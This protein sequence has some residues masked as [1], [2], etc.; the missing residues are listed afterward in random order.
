MLQE[1]VLKYEL[2]ISNLQKE[3]G[4][5]WTPNRPSLYHVHSSHPQSLELRNDLNLRQKLQI[6]Q[7]KERI[8]FLQKELEH[9]SQDRLDLTSDMSRQY[10]TM[11]SQMMSKVDSLE[12]EVQDLMEQLCKHD[13]ALFGPGSWNSCVIVT[14]VANLQTTHLETKKK[15][16]LQAAEK[17]MVIEEQGMKMTYMTNEFETML[18]EMLNRMSKKLEFASSKWKENDNLLISD[19]NARRLEEFGLTRIALGNFGES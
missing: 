8:D 4:T 13:I 14:D 5:T 2:E 1:K 16:E 9:K 19:A 17:D 3:L 6:S 15:Y 7:Q 11:Q 10:K 18:N 12:R